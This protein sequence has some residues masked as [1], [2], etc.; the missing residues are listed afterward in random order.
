VTR[1]RKKRRIVFDE[2]LAQEAVAQETAAA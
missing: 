2:V 1:W